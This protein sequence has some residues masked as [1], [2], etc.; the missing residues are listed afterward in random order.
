MVKCNLCNKRIWWLQDRTSID[1]DGNLAHTICFDR[2]KEL[3]L[4][5]YERA[6]KEQKKKSQKTPEENKKIREKILEEI[7][8]EEKSK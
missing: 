6:K 2:C 1:E 5:E 7:E 3:L 8:E 4:K